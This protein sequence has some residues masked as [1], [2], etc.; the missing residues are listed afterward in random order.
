MPSQQGVRRDYGVEFEQCLS[1]YSLGLA[2]QEGPLSIREAQS[3]SAQPVLEQSVLGLK[4]L[5]NDQLMTMDPASGDH[6]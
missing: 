5:D 6:Q 3:P 4:E 2:R 1:P